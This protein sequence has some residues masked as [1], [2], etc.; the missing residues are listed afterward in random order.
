MWN[1]IV[2]VG[3]ELNA[4]LGRTIELPPKPDERLKK[5]AKT[6]W[7]ATLRDLGLRSGKLDQLCHEEET[8]ECERRIETKA[9]SGA[10]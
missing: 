6:N 3:S 7:R 9:C 2:P 10:A 5:S 4:R 1:L 8:L